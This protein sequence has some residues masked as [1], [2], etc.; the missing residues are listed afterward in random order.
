MYC[1]YSAGSK[2]SA[3]ETTDPD[4][5]KGMSGGRV[6]YFP[7]SYVKRLRPGDKIMQVAHA[8]EV[9]DRE[10]KSDVI[11]LLKEQVNTFYIFQDY[12][13]INLF[14]TGYIGPRQDKLK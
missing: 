7:A 4:W 14:L 13:E 8:F 6:G 11:R 12:H 2:V 10:N 9:S 3:L 5:W 1:C